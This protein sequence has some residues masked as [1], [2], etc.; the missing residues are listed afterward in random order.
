MVL[1]GGGAGGGA[2]QG[3]TV[4]APIPRKSALGLAWS[5]LSSLKLTLFCLAL[6]MVLVVLCT[7]AQVKL[8]TFAAVDIYIRSLFVYWTSRDGVWKIPIFPG[9]GLVGLVLLLNLAAAQFGR[10]ERSWRKAGIWA[11][12][13]GLLLLFIGEFVTGFFQVETQMAIEEGQTRSYLE[14][15]RATE[16]AVIDAGESS[17]DRVFAF[18]EKALLSKT[19]LGHQ[20]LPFTITVKKAY[21]NSTVALRPKGSPFAAV[22]DRGIGAGMAVFP[23]DP[24]SRDDQANTVSALVELS[25]GERALGSW[26]VSSALGAEQAFMHKGRTWRLAI[27]ARRQYLPFSLAL[28][29]FRHERHPGTDIPRHFSSLLRL[30]D[31]GRG[32]DRDVLISMNQPLRYAGM[33]FYQASFGQDDTLS[34]LQV[35]RNPGWLIPYAACILVALG[36]IFHFLWRFMPARKTA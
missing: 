7:L 22:A 25:D 8:G 24:V 14:S 35:V 23:Q 26:L 10:L 19:R 21:P 9:G 33:T 17:S 18:S 1:Q 11:V 15:P 12:H 16:L 13:I 4:V 2:G 28:K 27:R 5:A 32:Q 30:N 29:D 6:L 36:L 31:P 20:D 34:I 3:Q